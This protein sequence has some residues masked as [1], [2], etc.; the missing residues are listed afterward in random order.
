MK[1]IIR[2]T[3]YNNFFFKGYGKGEE[4]IG[5]GKIYKAG[6]EDAQKVVTE[7]LCS[8]NPSKIELSLTNGPDCGGPEDG[9]LLSLWAWNPEVGWKLKISCGKSVD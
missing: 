2:T 1:S 6:L 3:G 8:K 9:H 7:K 4:I 5:E